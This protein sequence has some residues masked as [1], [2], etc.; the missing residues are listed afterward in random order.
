MIV[1]KNREGKKI[2][3]LPDNNLPLQIEFKTSS[4]NRLYKL[5]LT[6]AKKLILN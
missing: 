6:R 1:I 5:L 2:L 3:E 4:I